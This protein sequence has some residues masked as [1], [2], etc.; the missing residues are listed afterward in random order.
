MNKDLELNKWN[1]KE[2]ENWERESSN[3]LGNSETEM[4]SPEGNDRREEKRILS[5]A[6]ENPK[7][8]GERYVFTGPDLEELTR[9]ISAVGWIPTSTRPNHD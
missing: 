4:C 2:F 1:R 7:K 5:I 3:L 9:K 8:S 6:F